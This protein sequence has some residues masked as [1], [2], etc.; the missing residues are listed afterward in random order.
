ML[1]LTSYADGDG[2]SVA[3]RDS[4]GTANDNYDFGGVDDNYCDGGFYQY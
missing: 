1:I 3:N 2:N 4:Y